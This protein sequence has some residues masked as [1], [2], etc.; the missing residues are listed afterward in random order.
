MLAAL[1]HRVAF[2]LEVL[3]GPMLG[4]A[5][6]GCAAWRAALPLGCAF[7]TLLSSAAASLAFPALLVALYSPPPGAVTLLR[8]VVTS[9]PA[10]RAARD[11]ALA[12]GTAA[13]A[14]IGNAPLLTR[15]VAAAAAASWAALVLVSVALRSRSN[16]TPPPNAS[17]S[18]AHA[19]PTLQPLWAVALEHASVAI[20]GGLLVAIAARLAAPA[21]FPAGLDAA[22]PVRARARRA[23]AARLHSLSHVFW[24]ENGEPTRFLLPASSSLPCRFLVCVLTRHGAPVL[25][26]SQGAASSVALSGDGSNGSSPDSAAAAVSVAA[27][28][29]AAARAAA[30]ERLL[31]AL[32]ARFGSC[33]SEHGLLAA[34][35]EAAMA[36][37]PGCVAAAMGTLTRGYGEAS[38]A[39]GGGRRGSS[40]GRGSSGGGI[41]SLRSH[42]RDGLRLLVCRARVAGVADALDEAIAGAV[43]GWGLDDE[44][45]HAY[46]MLPPH[47]APYPPPLLP[48]PPPPPP[49]PAPASAP[50]LDGSSG[51]SGASSASISASASVSAVAVASASAPKPFS[52]A[53]G[54]NGWGALPVDVHARAAV[55]AAAAAAERAAASAEAAAAAVASACS[56]VRVLVG[57]AP[58]GLD[59]RDGRKCASGLAACPVRFVEDSAREFRKPETLFDLCL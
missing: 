20:R 21:P 56:A 14:R 6:L 34:A 49:P 54:S 15:R 10:F 2:L 1:P 38:A 43:G 47:S 55:A 16:K 11:V 27:A 30:E 46:A 53:P 37:A 32:S 39:A 13:R 28:S 12:A 22:S 26:V 45:S 52:L 41:G 7:D 5:A 33:T 31:S 58:G 25:F 24:R 35:A 29:A 19:F 40:D 9:P 18:H 59:S 36:L 50:S 23:G 57:D 51:S 3:R 17:P 8:E 48:P 44:D 42:R 4:A